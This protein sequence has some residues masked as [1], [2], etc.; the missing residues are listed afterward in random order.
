MY[1]NF[2]ADAFEEVVEGQR[3]RVPCVVGVSDEC[4]AEYAYLGV[5]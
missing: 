4:E 1:H 5:L 3:R 2:F